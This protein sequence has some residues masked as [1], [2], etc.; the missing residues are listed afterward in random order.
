MT[1]VRISFHTILSIEAQKRVYRA[2]GETTSHARTGSILLQ[3][4]PLNMLLSKPEIGNAADQVRG[5]IHGPR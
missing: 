5:I 2:D 1:K 4:Y 3:E